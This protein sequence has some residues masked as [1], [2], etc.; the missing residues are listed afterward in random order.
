MPDLTL[1]LIQTDLHWENG[2]ANLAMFD[3][4]MTGI[5]NGVDLVVLPEM[6]TTGFTMNPAAVAQ[7]M[8]GPAVAWLKA[9]SRE[10]AA[11]IAGSVV[12]GENGRFFN[13]LLWVKPDGTLLCYDKRHLFRM[14]GEHEVYTPGSGLLTVTL[15]G[16]RLRP[17]ICYDL[18]FPIWTRNLYGAYDVAVFVA[19]WP[20]A[21]AVHWQTLLAAR[22]IENQSY[23]AAVNRIGADGNGLTFDGGST[24]IDPWGKVVWTANGSRQAHQVV[25]QRQVLDECRRGF[26]A[27]MDADRNLPNP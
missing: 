11:D 3:A 2:P 25:L 20:A 21:R 8:D 6:F 5:G 22:A 19:N 14:T 7:P 13:R 12:I 10:I 4:L 24:L 15:N 27:W 17:F 9:K 1:A 18:R 23:V 26:P 16:W